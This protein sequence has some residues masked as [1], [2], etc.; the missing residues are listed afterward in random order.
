MIKDQN[1]HY[2]NAFL[3]FMILVMC[4]TITGCIGSVHSLTSTSVPQPTNTAFPTNTPFP[5][6]TPMPERGSFENPLEIGESIVVE[7]LLPSETVSGDPFIIMD[8]LL[9]QVE[10][11]DKALDLAKS[12]RVYSNNFPLLEEQEYLAVNVKLNLISSSDET[13]VKTLY[14]YWHL[15]LRYD[16]SGGD[17]WSEDFVAKFAEG[18]V[19]IEGEGWVFFLI[20]KGSNPYLYFS[21]GL[22]ATEQVGIRDRGAFFKLT[23]IN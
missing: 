6:K 11:G 21:P 17:T 10:R 20:K 1:L 5:T 7:P 13:Q 16:A 8:C 12:Q 15:T 2:R 9:L 23:E 4:I 19:P 22:I 18:Y 3:S 14:P